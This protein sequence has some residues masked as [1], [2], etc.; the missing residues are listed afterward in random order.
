[1]KLLP[2]LTSA[3]EGSFSWN[4]SEILQVGH[5]PR[6]GNTGNAPSSLAGDSMIVGMTTYI[7]KKTV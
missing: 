2:I 3:A 7:F 5:L 6:R 1:M 4:E